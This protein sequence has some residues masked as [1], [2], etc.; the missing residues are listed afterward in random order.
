MRLL[1]R[2]K[3]AT[4]ARRKPAQKLVVRKSGILIGAKKARVGKGSY[5]EVNP[6]TK[7]VGRRAFAKA[8]AR[9]KPGK[10]LAHKTVVGQ[11]ETLR[12]QGIKYVDMGQ[13]IQVKEKG[14]RKKITV[15]S[16]IEQAIDAVNRAYGVV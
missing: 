2:G 11:L 5:A 15:L 14:K 4:K 3:A 7:Y 13:A 12:R 16:T 8:L 1:R 9:V 6:G 10:E